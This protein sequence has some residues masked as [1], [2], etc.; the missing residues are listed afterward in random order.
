MSTY[1]P[2]QLLGRLVG[3][4]MYSVTFIFDYIQLH[5]QSEST[6]DT[7][8]LNCDALP[9]V[10]FRGTAYRPTD[11]GYADALRGMI[12]EVVV[13]TEEATGVGL[14]LRF[15]SGTITVHEG[16]EE[17]VE[18]AM[19]SGFDDRQWMVETRRGLVRRL[20]RVMTVGKFREMMLIRKRHLVEFRFNV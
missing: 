13:V 9:T 1:V 3:Y 8:F 6:S 10:E 15:P 11:F 5:F 2:N 7:P 12:P 18:M 4:Q 19:L 16:A 20:G 17:V 14:R